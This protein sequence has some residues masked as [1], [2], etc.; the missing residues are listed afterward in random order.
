MRHFNLGR[1]DRHER[2]GEGWEHRVGCV[3]GFREMRE[4]IG[5]EEAQ[6]GLVA[7]LERGAVVGI[8]AIFS[9]REGSYSIITAFEVGI[10]DIFLDPRIGREIQRAIIIH[11]A[12]R[13]I[14]QGILDGRPIQGVVPI[15]PARVEFHDGVRVYVGG[16]RIEGASPL[17]GRLGLSTLLVREAVQNSWDARDDN[18]GGKPVDFRIDGWDLDGDELELHDLNISLNL[19]RT[20]KV[21]LPY[22]LILSRSRATLHCSFE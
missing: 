13:H 4:E 12:N 7:D 6:P 9:E 11:I 15:Q 1:V 18:R 3:Y 2:R 14:V 22:L 21:V 16:G 10:H 8:I 20:G 19:L 5:R 17:S